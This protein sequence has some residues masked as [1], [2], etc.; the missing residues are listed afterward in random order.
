ME[1]AQA[2]GL[3]K[4]YDAGRLDRGSV[5]ALHAHFK[6]CE[7]C[8]ARARLRRDGARAALGQA[9]RGPASPD[10]QSQIVRN[11]TL[12]IQI[13]FLMI[14]AWFVWKMKR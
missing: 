5:R 4:D 13:L 14:F 1:H 12:L 6:D 9:D 2:E 7:A 11:R 8:R 10:L 3:F